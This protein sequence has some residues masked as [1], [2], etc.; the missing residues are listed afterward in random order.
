MATTSTSA[1]I[2]S[3]VVRTGRTL[4][5]WVRIVRAS[6]LDPHD[7]EAVHRWLRTEHGLLR[8]PAWTV[9]D[10]AAR[11]SAGPRP[12]VERLRDVVE[13]FGDD[14]VV[15]EDGGRV[16][17]RRGHPFA[18]AAARGAGVRLELRFAHPPG[19]DRMAE[20]ADGV[21]RLELG[22]VAEIDG[23]VEALLQVAYSQCG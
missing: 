15:D 10:A 17:F 9:A 1:A 2:G 12:V 7:Q 11:A 8:G 14:V 5:E 21:H 22:S 13:Q 4:D 18:S 23:E 3:V 20:A 16:L 6:G 19:S